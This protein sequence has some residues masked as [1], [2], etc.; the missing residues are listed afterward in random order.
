MAETS[1]L[2]AVAAASSFSKLIFALATA[3]SFSA[4]LG[5]SALIL[6]LWPSI[7]LLIAA[8]RLVNTSISNSDRVDGSLMQ[9]SG[10]VFKR[11]A[12]R[13]HSFPH[14]SSFFTASL[15]SG[16]PLVPTCNASN[17]LASRS[18]RMVFLSAWP[19]ISFSELAASFCAGFKAPFASCTAL[20]AALCTSSLASSF[21][22]TASKPASASVFAAVLFCCSAGAITSF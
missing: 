12:S 14:F 9:V 22:L 11:I 17:S 7:C 4:L 8:F 5:S 10:N 16:V 3:A 1:P 13:L 18:E 21:A 6:S 20:R 19:C 2:A 15:P